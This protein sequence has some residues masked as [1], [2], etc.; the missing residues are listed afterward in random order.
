MAHFATDDEALTL[1]KLTG[2]LLGFTSVVLLLGPDAFDGMSFYLGA[3]LELL[4]AVLPYGVTVSFGRRFWRL[5]VSPISTATL[6]FTGPTILLIPI[7][8]LIDR[9]WSLPMLGGGVVLSVMGLALL[10]TAVAY[11]LY[12]RILEIEGAINLSLVTLLVPVSAIALG[13][14]PWRDSA[15]PPP[16]WDDGDRDLPIGDRWAD[17][18]VA[19]PVAPRLAGFSVQRCRRDASQCCRLII[20]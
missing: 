14:F 11:F 13:V 8:V 5:G 3:Q 19:G 7:V 4:M 20:V 16:H 10:S 15:D 12:F 6:N 9:P 18:V 2:V 17:I 1:P